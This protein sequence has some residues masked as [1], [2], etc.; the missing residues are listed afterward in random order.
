MENP[1]VLDT[2]RKLASVGLCLVPLYGPSHS[3]GGKAPRITKWTEK[4]TNDVTVV[5]R[6]FKSWSDAN[7]GVLTG[8]RSGIVVIDC[9]P[10]NGADPWIQ[11]H[12]AALVE[13][14]AIVQKT[15]SGGIH[16]FF[17]HP[18]GYIATHSGQSGIAPGVEL[19]ADGKGKQ[20]VVAPS[21]NGKVGKAYEWEDMTLEDL[22][23]AG[24]LP[25]WIGDRHEHTPDHTSTAVSVIPTDISDDVRDA[26]LADI[27]RLG[28]G[29]NGRDRTIG[30]WICDAIAAGLGADE[31]RHHAVEWLEAHGRDVSE[32]PYEVDNWIASAQRKAATGEL[33]VSDVGL[34]AEVAFADEPEWPVSLLE[35]AQNFHAW[36]NRLDVTQNG[37]ISKT[38][39]K[40][41][42]IIYA[43]HPKFL[44]P[45]S[46]TSPLC[47]NEFT[48][49]IWLR[50]P[51]VGTPKAMCRAFP[52]AGKAFDDNDLTHLRSEST[53]QLNRGLL[54]EPADDVVARAVRL[55]ANQNLV[56]PVRNYLEALRWDGVP[57]VD[58][59]LK[60]FMAATG[61]DEFISVVGRKWL[62][63]AVAR[64]MKPGCKVDHA[65]VLVGAQ[66][67]GKSSILRLLCP[68][69]DWFS[70]SI[71]EDRSIEDKD[72]IQKLHG[73]WIVELPEN[74]VANKTSEQSI[75]A[76]LTKQEDRFRE[77]YGRFPKTVKRQC[78][79]AITTNEDEFLRDPSGGRRYWPVLV[80]GYL[81]PQK[82]EH[83]R[84]QLWA[85]AFYYYNQGEKW[86][87]T[88]P[89]H[90]A[91]AEEEQMLR[92][93][94]DARQDDL[95]AW[96]KK[97][98]RITIKRVW[99]ECFERAEQTL[100]RKEQM[101][102]ANMLRLAGYHKI[103]SKNERIWVRDD[104]LL[105]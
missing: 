64:V 38:S 47:Y 87:L 98:D 92:T 72:T 34:N 91:M 45:G 97:Q 12:H 95:E 78:V 1:T 61:N 50:S 30:R 53:L 13:A 37:M 19:L 49:S 57:R 39:I 89:K 75:K 100:D 93:I 59:W 43:N 23:F 26:L 24:V 67:L 79:F 29:S 10:R 33:Y 96:L 21:V 31:V 65:L 80:R 54:R 14:G 73:K 101:Q 99:T 77:A 82:I 40:N 32:Q 55:V 44:I 68:T 63:S 2:A 71:G 88:D 20:V 42:G 81:D 58:T 6:W 17:R 86:W 76:F 85:E 48:E 60:D 70:D 56:H 84:D 69:E 28:V 83:V 52:A 16:Y 35:E 22:E 102:V 8:I 18:G 66:G 15:P 51:I 90:L 103:R 5:E 74:A 36:E 94:T 4:A 7:L 62:I 27:S 41:V 25:E 105:A 46:E 9:D 11:E 104:D 3:T